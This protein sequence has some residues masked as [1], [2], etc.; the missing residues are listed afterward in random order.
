MLRPAAIGKVPR[1][2]DGAAM[3]LT[4]SAPLR[5]VFTLLVSVLSYVAA[6]ATWAAATGAGM[7]N[8]EMVRRWTYSLPT[9]ILVFWIGTEFQ[10]VDDETNPTAFFVEHLALTTGSNLVFQ[11]LLGYIFEANLL[12]L[13][14]VAMGGLAGTALITLVRRRWLVPI[15]G[16]EG[17]LLVGSGRCSA[18]AFHGVKWHISDLPNGESPGPSSTAP[19]G[20]LDQFTEVVDRIRPGRI[21]VQ[22]REWKRVPASKLLR[23]RLAGTELEYAG[24]AYE[25]RLHRVAIQEL[26]RRELLFAPALKSGRHIMAIQAIYTDLVGLLFLVFLS[27]LLVLTALMVAMFCGPGPIIE[28]VECAGFQYVPF[29]L[30]RFRTRTARTGRRNL[31]GRVIAGLHLVNLPQLINIVRG[32]V[33]FIGP[34]PVREEFAARLMQVA[35]YYC[36]LFSVKPGVLG[37]AQ[38][39]LPKHEIA[40]EWQRLEYDFYY[41]KHGSL[42]LDAQILIRTLLMWTRP[43]YKRRVE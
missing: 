19:V 41:I 3:T 1:F 40:S 33:V 16:H 17:A 20:S 13:S 29:R 37:W 22:G 24:R 6:A 15:S 21:V 35:P 9:A 12:P 32:E 25:K 34:R 10:N 2:P 14:V 43:E 30:L 38:C 27:P 28:S 8:G 36:H 42:A 23:L 7:G 4:F 39:N 31:A 26:D 5:S 11:A 18:E